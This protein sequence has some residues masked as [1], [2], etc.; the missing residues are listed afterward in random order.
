MVNEMRLK[1]IQESIANII[2][3]IRVAPEM[4]FEELDDNNSS[5]SELI[6]S[7]KIM[8]AELLQ[9][10]DPIKT[11]VDALLQILLIASILGI[12]LEKEVSDELFKLKLIVN[13]AG[14]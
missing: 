3:S 4:L 7:S 9:E 1:T 5:I 10:D 6:L 8:A 14:A 13:T 11:L 12:D 2:K